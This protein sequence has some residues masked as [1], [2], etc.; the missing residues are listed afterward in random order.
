MPILTNSQLSGRW[1]YQFCPLGDEVHGFLEGAVRRLG[2]SARAFT[3]ILRIARTIADLEGVEKLGV[4]FL[5]EAI[6]YRSM[7]RPGARSD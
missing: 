7:D 2:L 1:L 4:E 5:A 6:N 3:R